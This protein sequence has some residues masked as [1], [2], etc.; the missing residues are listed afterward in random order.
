MLW[1]V[2]EATVQEETRTAERK[3]LLKRIRKG[4]SGS[5][6]SVDDVRYKSVTWE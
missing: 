1:I 2:A 5:Q 6:L 4:D 3:P